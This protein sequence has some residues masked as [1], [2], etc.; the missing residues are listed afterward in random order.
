MKDDRLPSPFHDISGPTLHSLTYV[1]SASADL[2]A[3]ALLELLARWRPKNHSA[4]LTGMLLFSGGNI[5]QTL[6]GPF[7]SVEGVFTTIDADSRHHGVIALHREEIDARAFPDWS[8][9]FGRYDQQSGLAV[10]GTSAF[11]RQRTEDPHSGSALRLLEIF[12]E[13]MR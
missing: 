2:S 8:M 6:E 13:T 9:G 3:D 7:P 10:E 5:I 1:S 4:G 12:R 11:L